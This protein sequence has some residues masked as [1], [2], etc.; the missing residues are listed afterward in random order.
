MEWRRHMD[1]AA[2]LVHVID[3][4]SGGPSD[5]MLELQNVHNFTLEH[6]YEHFGVTRDAIEA[7]F[8]CA[9][10]RFD[11]G[12]YDVAAFYLGVYR[13]LCPTGEGGASGSD[14]SLKALW[15]RFAGH[16]LTTSW[17]EADKDRELL[18][19]VLSKTRMPELESLQQRTWLLHWSLFVFA[20]HPKGKDNLVDFFLQDSHMNAIQL[21]AP[22]LLR[23]VCAVVLTNKKR[24]NYM[25]QILRIISQEG[26]SYVDPVSCCCCCCLAA[27]GR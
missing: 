19:G 1:A 13:D 11:C 22:W 4:G 27:C 20:N 12:E 3:N 26:A 10:F 8:D 16:M 17:E 15:G 18:R 2:P 24:Q 21:N 25:R 5:T 7:L 9:K 23:Y 6:L 14:R